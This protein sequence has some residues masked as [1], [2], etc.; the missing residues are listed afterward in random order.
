[1]KIQFNLDLEHWAKIIEWLLARLCITIFNFMKH[2]SF[3]LCATL[4]YLWHIWINPKFKEADEFTWIIFAHQNS[5]SGS[6]RVTFTVQLV[7]LSY[8]QSYKIVTADLSVEKW[9]F[10]ARIK[11]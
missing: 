6:L 2:N 1:M 3:F 9:V 11:I 4:C 10:Q 5:N 7:Q 8:S